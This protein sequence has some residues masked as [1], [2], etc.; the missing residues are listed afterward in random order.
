MAY[1]SDTKTPRGLS[2]DVAVSALQKSIRRSRIYDA[3]R[4]A[5]EIESVN[6]P[7]LW[8]RLTV[9]CSEDI[10]PL[11]PEG[12]AVIESLRNQYDDAVRR[13][14]SAYR[15]YLANAVILLASRPKCR[16]VDNMLIAAYTDSS[17]LIAPPEAIDKHT[18]EGKR[19]GMG[20]N[21][22][23]SEGTKLSPP[24]DD[25]T[26]CELDETFSK[27][28]HERLDAGAFKGLTDTWQQSRKQKQEQTTLF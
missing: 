2:L 13:K 21:E 20:Y 17:P 6:V 4:F 5:V 23:F 19:R 8:N 10:G 27:I 22:F 26:I 14:N 3:L 9:I 7:V 28:A 25:A 12:P 24:V 18:A 11:W 15:L 16:V 1:L